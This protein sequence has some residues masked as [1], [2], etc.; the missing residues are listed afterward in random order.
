MTAALT[1]T[2]APARPVNLIG[3]DFATH[4]YEVYEG[5]RERAPVSPGRISLMRVTLL[6]RYDDCRAVLTDPRFVRNRSTATGGSR[7]PFPVP[8]SVE[9]LARSMIVEDDPEHRRL[10]GLVQQAFMPRAL[11]RIEERVEH[12]T[13]ELLDRLPRGQSFDLQEAYCLPIPVTVISEMVGVPSED[14]P[15]F[16]DCMRVLSQGL[17]GWSVLRTLFRDLPTTV[18]FVRGLIAR[19]REE[20][21]E[22]ILS[23][24]IAAE[25]EGDRLSEDELVSMVFLL[26]A[27]GYETTV[28]LI[29][30]G[31]LT[32]IEHPEQL[33]RLRAEP[34]LVHSAVE[35]IVRYRGPVHATKPAY[36]TQDVELHGVRIPRGATVMPL[37]GAANHDPRE[38]DR[39][40]VFDIARDPNRHLG[41]GYG[42]HFCLG[43]KLA[44]METRIA[45]TR[46]FE[47]CPRLRL[48]VAPS[49]LKLANLPGWHR[50]RGLPVMAD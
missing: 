30:N 15:R 45:L 12:L 35:E 41:F 33:E 2:P 7:L 20:P 18:R 39:P 1:P 40:E 17:T 38:F 31:V 50:Y 8:R 25:E 29:T 22:D 34:G 28:H 21:G 46:L 6:S 49:E 4:K 10:R 47:R 24:L 37:L 11:G 3:R 44:R 36:P 19:K 32:L 48:A 26:I 23:A 5:L 27:A 16:H 9:L 14:M 13:E 43:A 42:N